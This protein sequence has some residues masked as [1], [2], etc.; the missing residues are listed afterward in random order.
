MRSPGTK[1]SQE[2]GMKLGRNQ[3]KT[4]GFGNSARKKGAT[5]TEKGKQVE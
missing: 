4:S 5:G 2:G 3:G 1:I